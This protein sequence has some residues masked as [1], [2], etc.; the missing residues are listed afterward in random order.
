MTLRSRANY[1]IAAIVIGGGIV[2]T[3]LHFFAESGQWA[4]ASMTGDATKSDQRD[5]VVSNDVANHKK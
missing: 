5:A 2:L 3:G 4:P 1:V